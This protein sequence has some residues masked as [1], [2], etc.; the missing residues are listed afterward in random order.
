MTCQAKGAPLPEREE[1]GLP[2]GWYYY[3]EKQAGLFN[4]T[5][6]DLNFLSWSINLCCSHADSSVAVYG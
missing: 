1:L 3:K 4:G 5:R 2:Y 6:Q